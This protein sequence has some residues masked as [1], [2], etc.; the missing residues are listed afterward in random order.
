MRFLEHT[1]HQLGRMLECLADLQILNDTLI[2]AIIGDN[3]ASAEGSL[4][5]DIP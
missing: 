4:Q 2:Y 1:D 5:G 3:G